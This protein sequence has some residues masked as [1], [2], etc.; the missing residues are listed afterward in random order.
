AGLGVESRIVAVGR[1]K[2]AR[3]L[4]PDIAEAE[5]RAEADL[6]FERQVPLL[7][8][9]KLEAPLEARRREARV[10]ACRRIRRVERERGPAA[11]NRLRVAERARKRRVDGD[12]LKQGLAAGSQVTKTPHPPPTPPPPPP[13]PPP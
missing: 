6:A 7:V 4:I 8:R 10:T 3:A 9:R 13:P 11:L 5:D 1:A 2:E 12:C